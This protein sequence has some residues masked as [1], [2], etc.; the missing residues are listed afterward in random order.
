MIANSFGT[1]CIPLFEGLDVVFMQSGLELFLVA[2]NLLFTL[3]WV[4]LYQL[5][6]S[7]GDLDYPDGEV[8]N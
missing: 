8:T 4:S 2:A 7:L 3:F 5:G 1:L 6:V